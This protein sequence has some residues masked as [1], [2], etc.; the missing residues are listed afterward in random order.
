MA[1]TRG[2]LKLGGLT[3]CLWKAMSHSKKKEVVN[4]FDLKAR[5]K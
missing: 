4:S 2:I 5:R 3:F 1:L